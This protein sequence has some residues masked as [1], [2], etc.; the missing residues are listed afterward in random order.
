MKNK[1][2]KHTP[3]TKPVLYVIFSLVSGL[4][5][6]IGCNNEQTAKSIDKTDSLAL[7]MKAPTDQLLYAYKLPKSDFE[8]NWNVF[9]NEKK[10]I[11]QVQ[12]DPALGS[13]N[14]KLLAHITDHVKYG[15]NLTPIILNP[16]GTGV[17]TNTSGLIIGNLD[18]NWKAIVQLI[19]KGNDIDPDFDHIYL[20]PGIKANYLFYHVSLKKSDGSIF[21]PF[22]IIS[23]ADS[24]LSV[25][26]DFF[27][28]NPSPPA[29]P[30]E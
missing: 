16:I 14:F 10:V 30:N 12:F 29:K 19:K 9:K 15:E 7:E 20:E 21:K 27:D 5:I 22:P 6:F 18:L 1:T 4:L 3:A 2:L 13:P 8:S 11:F 24:S 28:A 25:A 23:L 17:N 26:W